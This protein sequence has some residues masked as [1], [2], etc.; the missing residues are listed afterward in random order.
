MKKLLMTMAVAS[1]MAAAFAQSD[2]STSPM[3]T[4]VT[5][6]PDGTVVGLV[7]ANN[8]S[9]EDAAAVMALA[10]DLNMDP[11]AII[12][13]R[14]SVN[15][16]F[17]TLAPAFIL[18]QQSGKQF[19][20]IWNMYTGGKT[21]TQIATELNVDPTYYNPLSA[22]AANW[23]NDDFNTG[24]WQAILQK[25][26]GAT[27]EDFSY[28]T[29]NTV[30]YNE[31]VVGEVLARQD[32]MPARDVITSYNANKDWQALD[33]KWQSSSQTPASTSQPMTPPAP[34][35]MPPTT[36]PPAPPPVVMPPLT[37]PEN[38]PI[39]EPPPAANPNTDVMSAPNT[40]TV[41]AD[42]IAEWQIDGGDIVAYNPNYAF[43]TQTTTSTY[44]LHRR[45]RTVWHRR[46]HG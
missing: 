10:R 20:D 6:T 43:T 24:V 39:T 40:N 25:N 35:P 26:Y 38:P 15:A 36:T 5:Q 41:E 3:T 18:Q 17:Y 19:S 34:A 9:W 29:A 7:K 2:G 8:I 16:P 11:N 13:T 45:H 46:R 44:A 33:T 42:P 27:S 4:T 23:T 22:N 28:F 31:V 30:P 37:P 21:W 1:V 14:G 32:N 12:T